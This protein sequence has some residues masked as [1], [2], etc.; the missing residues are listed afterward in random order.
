MT[1]VI[2]WLR[3]LPW[4]LFETLVCDWLGHKPALD[5]E[6]LPGLTICERCAAPLKFYKDHWDSNLA[7]NDIKP[8]SSFVNKPTKA[9]AP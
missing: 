6:I 8:L 1:Q 3:N 5:L 4:K 7:I 9:E 2:R